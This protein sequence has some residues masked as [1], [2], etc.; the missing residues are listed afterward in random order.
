MKKLITIIII[1]L[2]AGLT[3]SR[4]QT[5][6]L[7]EWDARFGG[8]SEDALRSLQQTANGGYIL[9]GVTYSGISGDKTQASQ[10]FNDYWMV[11][12]DTNGVKEWDARFGGS[13]SDDFRSLEQTADGGYILGGFSESGISG[14]KT[15]VSQGSTDYWI[16]KTDA[17]GVK[18]WDTRFGGSGEDYLISLQQT[19]DG[20]YIL[21]GYSD[22]EISGDKTQASQGGFDYWIVKTDANGI[23]QWDARFGGSSD[24]FF[25]SLEQ[26]ADAGYILGGFTYSAISG[27]KTQASQGYDDY[28][29]VKTD[30]NG[31]KQWDARFGGSS[32]DYLYSLKQTADEGYILGGR[33][34]SAISGDKTQ[35]SQGGFDYWIVKTDAIGVKQWDARFGGSSTDDLSSIQQ[36]IDGGYILG[37][38]SYSGINGDK[39]QASQGGPDYWIVKTDANGAKQWDARF[40]GSDYDFLLNSLQQTADGGY[41]LGGTSYSGVSGDKTQASQGGSDYWMV[42]VA[43]ACNGGLTVYAD[44]DGDGYGDA[45]NSLFV[46]DCVAPVGYVYNNTDCNDV[47]ENVHPGVCDATNGNGIDDNC[48][49]VLDNGFGATDYYIDADADGYG[50]GTAISLCSNPGAGYSTNDADCDDEDESVYPG[51]IEILNG[52]D[53]DCNGSIDDIAC[54]V[55]VNLSTT[56]ITGNSAELVW[57]PVAVASTYKLRYKIGSS[58][59]W[60]KIS[61]TETSI[62]INGLIANTKYV[63]QIKGKCGGDL[64]SIWSSKQHFTTSVL[65]NGAEQVKTLSLYPNPV[66]QSFTLNIQLGTTTNQSVTIHLLNVFGQT[67]YSSQEIVDGELTKVIT[68]PGTAASG[69][70]VVRVVMSDEV[71]E[72]KLMY[73]K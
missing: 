44:T 25:R 53:D 55:P 45:T 60:K 46:T 8:S 69:W 13:S 17:N 32:T 16:V 9:G 54:P 28:W 14:D 51:A 4:A 30:V 2:A 21:G 62:T 47:N 70:Y 18:Q 12:T 56:N 24:D 7:K 49:G 61:S 11:K 43:S 15:Q 73:Q 63:W 29:I 36:T 67:V 31:V 37:G 6:P 57:N 40:G 26:T 64:T 34:Y 52:I 50:S 65:R 5:A 1:L 38:D 71:I 68:M 3:S 59:S 33:S 20:G 39:T 10:G 72:Q 35:A 22:S 23:K 42:K 19:A 66:S 48:D 58:S 27:D 41:I